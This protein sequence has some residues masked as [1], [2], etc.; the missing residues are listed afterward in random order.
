MFKFLRRRASETPV[1]DPASAGWSSTQAERLLSQL[2]W[3]VLRRLDGQLQGDYRSLFRGSGLELA[4]LREYQAHD[5]VRHIDWNVTARMGIPHVREHQED[6]EVAAWFLIDVSGSM[7]VG[8]TVTKRERAAQAV[9]TLARLLSGRGNRVGAVLYGG[10]QARP[11]RVIPARSGRRHVLHVLHAL[12]QPAPKGGKSALTDLED[13]LQQVQSLIRRRSLV[14]VVSDFIAQPGWERS[15][16][17]LSSRHEVLAI[18]LSDPL[19]SE[20]PRSG[21]FWLEDA[22]TGEQMLLDASDGAMRRRFAQAAQAR[23]AQLQ[24]SFQQAG[25]DVLEL[26]TLEPLDQALLRFARLRKLAG[27]LA[28]GTATTSIAAWPTASGSMPHA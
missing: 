22:E 19:E 25:V 15:L 4:D 11:E 24:A 6:R 7:D 23:E 27:R 17:Q 8:A 18:R 13:L 1:S 3:T 5:D 16:A 20:L 9:G 12:L 10:T 28:A 21:M 14:V 26:D 2:E